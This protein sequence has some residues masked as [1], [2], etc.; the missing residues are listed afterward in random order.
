[1]CWAGCLDLVMCV[2]PGHDWCCRTVKKLKTLI[3]SC[4]DALMY[5]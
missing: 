4:R 5:N 1:M 2:E 3:Y